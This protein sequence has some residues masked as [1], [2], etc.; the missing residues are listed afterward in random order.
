[1][2][3]SLHLNSKIEYHQRIQN[4]LTPSLRNLIQ[5]RKQ[6]MERMMR[7]YVEKIL[8]DMNYRDENNQ[9]RCDAKTWEEKEKKLRKEWKEMQEEL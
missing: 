9:K 6:N 7:N 5:Q 1:M 8:S 3:D 4:E 2:P